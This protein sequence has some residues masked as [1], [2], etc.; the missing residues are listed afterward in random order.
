MV[1]ECLDFFSDRRCSV[2]PGVAPFTAHKEESGGIGDVS[3]NGTQRNFGG[4]AV[5]FKGNVGGSR[6]IDR[7]HI[8]P[9]I[10]RSSGK[11][12]THCH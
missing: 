11:P 4:R 10:K 6:N 7:H 5:R 3:H 2:A 8:P 1:G 12:P 9:V